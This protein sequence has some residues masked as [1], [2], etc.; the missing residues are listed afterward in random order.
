MYVS[1]N[2]EFIKLDTVIF[3]SFYFNI[4]IILQLRLISALIIN[5][6]FENPLIA[7]R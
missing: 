6:I 7:T 2:I 3:I 1:I 5:G 4:I